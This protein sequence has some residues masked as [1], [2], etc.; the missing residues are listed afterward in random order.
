MAD[1]AHAEGDFFEAGDFEALPVFDRGDVVARLEQRRGRA[2]IEPGHAAAEQFHVQLAALEVAKIEIGDLQLFARGRLQTARKIDSLLVINVKTGHGEMALRLFRFFL[3]ADCFA[4]G[5]ELDHAVTLRVAHLISENARAPFECE[6]FAV[7]VEFPVKDVVAENE[8]RAGVADELRADQKRLCDSLR[9][10][11]FSILNRNSELGAVR[12]VITQHRQIL[13]RRDDENVAQTAEH[14]RGKRV[15]DHRLVI[16][17][18]ELFADD[19]GEREEPRPG[20]AGEE[21]RFFHF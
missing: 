10:R 20:A 4:I 5:A 19:L 18:E 16:D 15:T 9:F 7:E 8:R 6:R 13:R 11:L 21:N 12:K 14:E 1:E 17:R 3:D 2:G